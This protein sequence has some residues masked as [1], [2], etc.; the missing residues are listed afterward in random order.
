MTALTVILPL[1]SVLA[2]NEDCAPIGL[3]VVKTVVRRYVP[4]TTPPFDI[5]PAFCQLGE[6][7]LSAGRKGPPLDGSI[8]GHQTDGIALSS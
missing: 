1:P 2:V 7:S 3:T 4:E 6:T 5:I 8:E